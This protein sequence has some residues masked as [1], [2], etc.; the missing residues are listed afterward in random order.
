MVSPIHYYFNSIELHWFY[1]LLQAP[2]VTL[3]IDAALT[4]GV[5]FHIGRLYSSSLSVSAVLSCDTPAGYQHLR[6][7]LNTPKV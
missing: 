4:L 6:D 3:G 7:S 5:P 1:S 2:L